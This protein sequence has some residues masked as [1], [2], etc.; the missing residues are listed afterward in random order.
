[1]SPALEAA[2]RLACTLP[3]KRVQAR[4]E[5]ITSKHMVPKT[6][7]RGHQRAIEIDGV[8]FESLTWA[9]KSL[10]KANRTIYKWLEEGRAKYV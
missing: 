4:R 7:R 3:N 5:F 8:V 6:S 1:M 9:A 10:H 2:F